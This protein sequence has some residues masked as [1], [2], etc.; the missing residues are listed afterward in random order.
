[1]P[2]S[3]N[4]LYFTLNFS[5]LYREELSDGFTE[6]RLIEMDGLALWFDIKTADLPAVFQIV[7][8]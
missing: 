1:M 8:G 4:F 5:R 2:R 3:T 6:Q 7:S